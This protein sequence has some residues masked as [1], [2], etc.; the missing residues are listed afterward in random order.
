MTRVGKELVQTKIED[1]EERWGPLGIF[2]RSQLLGTSWIPVGPLVCRSVRFEPYWLNALFAPGFLCVRPS[3]QSRLP[4][5]K[6]EQLLI[7]ILMTD[8]MPEQM[9]RQMDGWSSLCRMFISW[10]IQTHFIPTW[11]QLW[12]ADVLIGCTWPPF[13]TVSHLHLHVVSPASQ[14]PPSLFKYFSMTSWFVTPEWIE[15]RLKDMEKLT[16]G[17]FCSY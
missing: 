3:F 14:M 2:T 12:R 7:S 11:S 10:H 1:E 8:L 13:T 5:D 4:W 15:N 9:D 16:W 6:N 17:A